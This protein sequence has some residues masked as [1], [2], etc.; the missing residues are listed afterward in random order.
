[1]KVKLN[2]SR[3]LNEA[4]SPSMPKWLRDKLL[5]DMTS[6]TTGNKYNGNNEYYDG[7][8]SNGKFVSY[9]S[10]RDKDRNKYIG[11]GYKLNNY[12]K[13]HFAP[14]GDH[15][16][17]YGIL[18]A[19]HFNLDSAQF[20]TPDH[21]PK[22]SK[23]PMVNKP[24]IPIWLVKSTDY[25]QTD[26][27]QVYMKGFNDDELWG[28]KHEKFRY[29]SVKQLNNA[30]EGFCY[31][32][33]STLDLYNTDKVNQRQKFN[34][35]NI[36]G[37]PGSYYRYG[38]GNTPNQ[39][40]NY[41]GQNYFPPKSYKLDSSGYEVIP[42]AE[43][44]ADKLN[45]L[46]A[47]NAS[48]W[49]EDCYNTIMSYKNDIA[50]AIMDLDVK[51]DDGRKIAS[52][53]QSAMNSYYNCVDYYK[54]MCVIIDTGDLNKI[55]EAFTPWKVAYNLDKCCKVLKGYTAKWRTVIADWD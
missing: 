41:F 19:R 36:P 14:R 39:Y 17:L 13:P 4:F 12:A 50:G 31:V 23:D 7:Y 32:D 33:G 21:L 25:N 5:F 45:K 38:Q 29:T 53:I 30:C 35:K 6:T 1:M 37:K 55:A 24:N 49:L 8:D 46:K 10:V 20:I 9:Q 34:Q 11:K 43:K 51:S 42:P 18:R 16:N 44:Y 48:K 15:T 26:K 40:R 2:E 27:Y 47:K 54:H 3:R 52:D 22:N 28:E